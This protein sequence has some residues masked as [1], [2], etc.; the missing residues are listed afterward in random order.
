MSRGPADGSSGI[1]T[2]LDLVHRLYAQ[3]GDDVGIFSVFL[4]NY[5]KLHTGECLYIPANT[6]HAYLSGDIVECMATSD[7][8]VRG[9]LTTK[10][11]DIE[12]LCEMLRYE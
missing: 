8:V 4:F 2:C 6:P 5:A 1:A 11:K 10:F 12:V 9:G 3:Y 7:N